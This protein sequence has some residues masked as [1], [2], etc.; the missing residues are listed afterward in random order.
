[1][2][3]EDTKLNEEYDFDLWNV[4]F[5]LLFHRCRIMIISIIHNELKIEF[6]QRNAILILHFLSV[7]LKFSSNYII[8]TLSAQNW[9]IEIS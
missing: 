7:I 5:S 9:F 2:E 8:G 6:R 3:N 1:M 4:F